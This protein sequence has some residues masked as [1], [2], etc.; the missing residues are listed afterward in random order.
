M[1]EVTLVLSFE[2]LLFIDSLG[3]CLKKCLL[4]RR[5]KQGSMLSLFFSAFP[6]VTYC[7]HNFFLICFFFPKAEYYLY[8]STASFSVLNFISVFSLWLLSFFFFSFNKLNA[9]VISPI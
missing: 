5:Y 7:S 2:E 3:Q 9:S 6:S 4:F 8:G 1:N